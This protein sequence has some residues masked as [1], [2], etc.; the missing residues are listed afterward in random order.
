MVAMGVFES[1]FELT[2]DGGSV[3]PSMSEVYKMAQ[4]LRI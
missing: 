2:E 1:F 4:N 3:S